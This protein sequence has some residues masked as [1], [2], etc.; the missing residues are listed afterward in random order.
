M[1]RRSLALAAAII[2]AG[3]LAHAVAAADI[4]GKW[5][6]DF[7]T[8]IGVQKYTY[9]FQ[10]KG[11]ELTGTAASELGTTVIKSG[12]VDGETVTFLEPLDFM[13]MV[14]NIA[15]T[16][17]IV[18]DDQIDFT[19]QVADIATEKLVAKRVK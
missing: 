11:S 16:G 8:Q 17:K 7:D 14:I 1:T 18:S 2:A 15:Y 4:T 5:T 12:K 10:V 19:R 6:A 3:F 13:G 9:T